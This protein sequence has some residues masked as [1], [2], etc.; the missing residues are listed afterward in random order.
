MRFI[1]PI[2]YKL[3]KSQHNPADFFS[4]L[5]SILPLQKPIPVAVTG[6]LGS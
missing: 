3:E 1:C 6:L 2:L 5:I 4:Y